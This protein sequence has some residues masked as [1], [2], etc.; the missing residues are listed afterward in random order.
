MGLVPG[1]DFDMVGWC[2]DETYESGYVRLFTDG[3]VAP[4][5]VWSMAT[6]MEI[7]V[8]RVEE[9]RSHPQLPTIHLRIPTKLRF[10][11]TAPK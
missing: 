7:A 3:P 9:R 8:A 1:R 2:T 4:A 6:M 10:H 5:V 11:E